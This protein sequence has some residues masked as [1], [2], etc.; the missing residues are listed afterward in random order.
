MDNFCSKNS[1]Q[2]ILLLQ[3]RITRKITT[4]RNCAITVECPFG[5]GNTFLRFPQDTKVHSL[6]LREIPPLL[7]TALFTLARYY[8]FEKRDLPFGKVKNDIG[9]GG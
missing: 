4:D 7:T 1:H 2:T 9:C 5:Y 3:T 8:T 6:N